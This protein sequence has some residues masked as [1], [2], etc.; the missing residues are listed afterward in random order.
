MEISVG[1]R[2]NADTKLRRIIDQDSRMLMVLNRFGISF[3][4]G[5]KSIAEVC[6]EDNVDC[7]S[8]LAVCNFLIGQ[9]P[10]CTALSLAALMGY[11]RKA[12][13]YFLDFILPSIRT[14]LIGS[15][16]AG[17]P[18]T[19]VVLLLLKFYDDYVMEVRR[20]MEFENNIIFPYVESLLNGQPDNK[21]RIAN[22]SEGH[23]SAADKLE[24][25]KDI[26]IRH[27]H[28]K[29]NLMLTSALSDII[30]CHADLVSHCLIEDRLFIPEVERLEKKLRL[31]ALPDIRIESP[32]SRPGISPLDSISDREKEIIACVARGMTNKEIADKLF[33]SV[34]TVTTHRRNLAAKLEIHST[35]GLTIFAIIH[36]IIDINEVDPHL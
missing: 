3:G 7:P 5:D 17:D 28:Q 32:D 4:F 6:K 18:V 30:S 14:K 13:T 27:Y 33:L 9:E 29:D 24:E 15:I 19:D 31:T 20:H 36:N 10:D 26:F 22:Y 23:T 11:L 25:L 2:F 12:H 16:N 35:A 1:T 8:F 34:N 21:L